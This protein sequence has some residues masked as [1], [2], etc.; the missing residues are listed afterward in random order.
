MSEIK[1]QLKQKKMLKR[2]LADKMG[3]TMPTLKKKLD[4]PIHLTV[5]DIEKLR[6]LGFQ[7]TI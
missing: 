6:N 5:G 3:I 1:E 7:I 4:N 2:E